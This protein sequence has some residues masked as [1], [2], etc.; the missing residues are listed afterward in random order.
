MK[1]E[2][3]SVLWDNLKGLG[4]EEVGATVHDGETHVPL[5]LIHVNVQQKQPQNCK[6]IILQLK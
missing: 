1:Q 3:K 6:V 4:G 5:W 2:T